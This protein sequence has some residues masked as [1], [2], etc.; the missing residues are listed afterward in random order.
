VPDGPQGYA[1]HVSGD[2][3]ETGGPT[4]APGDLK[5][6]PRIALAQNRPNPFETGTAI[7]F[8]IPER[9]EVTLSVF[10]IAGR[11]VRSLVEGPLDAG[12]YTVTWNGRDLAGEPVAAGIY[13]YR[14]QG[15]RF[16]KTRKMVVLR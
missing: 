1:L 2:V 4:A 6:P 14:L 13:F 16:E 15:A 10:D 7:R 9:N 11:K 5:T 3:T 8:A 12:E